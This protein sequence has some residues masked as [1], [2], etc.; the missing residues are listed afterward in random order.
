MFGNKVI[1]NKICIL[2][3]ST[4]LSEKILILRKTERDMIKYVYWS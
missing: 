4:N 1:E 2:L 3:I